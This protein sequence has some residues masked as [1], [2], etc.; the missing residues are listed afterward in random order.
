M[1]QCSR[2]RA[3]RTGGIVR[4]G[5]RNTGIY[6][7]LPMLI[8]SKGGTEFAEFAGSTFSMPIVDFDVRFRLGSGGWKQRLNTVML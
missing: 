8:D 7:L 6:I 2:F 4:S 5:F 1:I 3:V